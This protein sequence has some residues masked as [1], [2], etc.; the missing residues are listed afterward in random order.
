MKVLMHLAKR[1]RIV[2]VT[3]S[4]VLH[5]VVLAL[6]LFGIAP[7]MI[8]GGSGGSSFG[9][10]RGSGFG[11]ELV[12][13]T[14]AD[15][16]PF[17]VKLPTAEDLTEPLDALPAVALTADVDTTISLPSEVLPPAQPSEPTPI[18][19]EDAAAER[20]G[21]GS[22]GGP[23]QGGTTIGFNDEL[24]QQVEPCWRRLAPKG[25]RN[26]YLRVNFSPLGNV[27]LTADA[28]PQSTADTNTI[29]LANEA[30]A[31][32]GPYVSAGSRENVLIGFP[33]LAQ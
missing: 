22:D 8:G 13:A 31:E 10:G 26:A 24:W 6:L 14:S 33:A 7:D 4:L 3:F 27:V 12:S 16:N 11:V 2:S 9:N 17:N 29:A 32:C 28:T 1:R 30:L 25:M 19:N 21:Q 23:G 18:A 15:A 5:A 20:S